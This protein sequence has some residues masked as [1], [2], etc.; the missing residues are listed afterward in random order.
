M[1]EFHKVLYKEEENKVNVEI[2]KVMVIE[3]MEYDDGLW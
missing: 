3:R 1:S 2:R